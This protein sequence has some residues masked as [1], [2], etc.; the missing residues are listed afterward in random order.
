MRGGYSWQG[1][2]QSRTTQQ[3][4]VHHGSYF[5][6]N[7]ENKLSLP[8]HPLA[9]F[10]AALSGTSGSPCVAA[11]PVAAQR[12]HP[13]KKDVAPGMHILTVKTAQLTT[14]E[15]TSLKKKKKHTPQSAN[16]ALKT[17]GKPRTTCT[18]QPC[19]EM[20]SQVLVAAL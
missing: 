1:T 17:N 19:T 18:V 15:T 13:V 12:P 5:N 7:I 9:V 4:Q 8:E 10:S 16:R 11:R 20:Q 3:P 6:T 2:P 14:F